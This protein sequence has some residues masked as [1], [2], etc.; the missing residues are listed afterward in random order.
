MNPPQTTNKL[1]G[2]DAHLV[3]LVATVLG[4]P[5]LH[6]DA[7]MRLHRQLTELLQ[8]TQ[9]DMRRPA[10]AEEPAPSQTPEDGQLPKILQA[11]LV[12]PNLHTDQRMRLH[13]QIPELI[14][15]AHQPAAERAGQLT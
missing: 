8:R 10:T 9:Q 15:A 1:D 6:T 4:D 7:R 13:N 11:V 3:D 14:R 2:A 5:N 12:D